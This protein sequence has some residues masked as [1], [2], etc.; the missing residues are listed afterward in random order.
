MSRFKFKAWNEYCKRMYIPKCLLYDDGYFK[1]GN[2]DC[3]RIYIPKVDH[4]LLQYTGE[5]DMNGVEIYEGD[6]VRLCCEYEDEVSYIDGL[7]EFK[8]AA[9]YISKLNDDI[10]PDNEFYAPNFTWS[11][12]EVIDNFYERKNV[13][14]WKR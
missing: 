3:E 2:F 7:V 8:E 4:I 9:F 12:L 5:K 10:N 11:S 14:K 13:E 1:T 6:I